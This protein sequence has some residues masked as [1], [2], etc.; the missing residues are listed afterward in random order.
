MGGQGAVPPLGGFD[1]QK[2]MTLYCENMPLC[3]NLKNDTLRHL[4]SLLT[5]VQYEMEDRS[6]WT[7]KSGK[8]SNN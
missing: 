8:S 5:S 4:H 2:L 1:P 6:V 3:H 7:Q